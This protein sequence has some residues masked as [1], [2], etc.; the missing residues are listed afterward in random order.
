MVPEENV[1]PFASDQEPIY[2]LDNFNK[3]KKETSTVNLLPPPRFQDAITTIQP[4]T[5]ACFSEILHGKLIGIWPIKSSN[6]LKG[7]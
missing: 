4:K 2:N 6:L 7:N 5:S 1:T 3:G